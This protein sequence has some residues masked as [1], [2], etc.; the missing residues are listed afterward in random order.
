MERLPQLEFVARQFVLN[1]CFTQCIDWSLISW[2]SWF[3]EACDVKQLSN[4]YQLIYASRWS[5][6]NYWSTHCWWSSLLCIRL[7]T[8]IWTSQSNAYYTA[9]YSCDLIIVFNYRKIWGYRVILVELIIDTLMSYS[10]PA[11]S[12]FHSLL[13]NKSWFYRQFPTSFF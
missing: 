10:L 11:R 8:L 12:W 2:C 1:S 13:Q 3:C 7:G 5:W 6:R 4:S 9:D